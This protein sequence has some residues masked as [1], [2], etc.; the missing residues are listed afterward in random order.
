MILTDPTINE[1]LRNSADTIC[2]FSVSGGKDGTAAALEGSEHLD[3]IGFTG[4]RILVHSDLGAIEHFDSLPA[5]NRLA[6]RMQIPLH[7]VKPN[8]PMIERWQYR[9]ECVVNRFVN[10]ETVRISTWASSAANRFCTSEEKTAPI[11]RFLKNEF[12]GKTILN[13]VGIRADESV[14]RSKEPISKF[15][16][17]L[18]VKTHGT[19]GYTWHPILKYA[20]EDVFLA[21]RRFGF[22]RHEAYT[23]FGLS[24]VSCCFC[25]LAK[26][27]DLLASL[28][29]ERN[30]ESYQRIARIEIESTFSF[31]NDFWLAD[32]APHLLTGNERIGLAIAKEKA[33]KRRIA[34][35]MIPVELL[36]DAATG[37]PAFQPNIKQSEQL[38]LARAEIGKILNLPVKYTSAEDVYNRYAELLVLKQIKEAKNKKQAAAQIDPAQLALF[39]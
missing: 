19:S 38:G 11:C 7:V 9:W 8:R 34:D 18:Y 14:K 29:D 23:R 30:H 33:I 24:R 15:N 31:K 6:D 4:K 26:E 32:L 25:V 27:Q 12:R 17:M 3:R 39:N 20:V 36:F 13:I 37:F 22:A 35:K 5:C 28:R 21:H 10:L 1:K 16:K 2:A